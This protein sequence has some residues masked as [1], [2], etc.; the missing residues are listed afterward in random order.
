MHNAQPC[1]TPSLEFGTHPTPRPQLKQFALSHL[2]QIATR[3]QVRSG[4]YR[5]SDLPYLPCCPGTICTVCILVV[6]T[7]STFLTSAASVAVFR[8]PP[9]PLINLLVAL[10]SLDRSIDRI[11]LP[12]QSVQHSTI[13]YCSTLQAH[14]SLRFAV[15]APSSL[16]LPACLP[17]A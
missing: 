17:K 13:Q 14:L 16:T 5:I 11:E 9:P 12:L 1:K 4:A 10:Q 3:L 7:H 2:P 6:L 15:P 8:S